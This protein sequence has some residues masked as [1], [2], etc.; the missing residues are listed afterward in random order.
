MLEINLNKVLE[1]F[2]GNDF[3]SLSL[4]VQ[5]ST[6]E[7]SKNPFGGE[8]SEDD[9]F[10]LYE[11]KDFIWQGDFD[12]DD[13][14]TTAIELYELFPCYMLSCEF[15]NYYRDF[16]RGMSKTVLSKL[17]LEFSRFMNM[18][19]AYK[20]PINYVLWVDFFEDRNTQAS[21]WIGM[22][23]ACAKNNNLHELAAISGP[24][25]WEFK[26][27]LYYKLI[28]NKNFHCYILDGLVA[29]IEDVY[30][31]IDKQEAKEIFLKLPKIE[32]NEH[33]DFLEK[34][35]VL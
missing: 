12:I 24:V 34:E 4:K 19:Q 25:E 9:D 31:D 27:H 16:G 15:Y 14:F 20:H 6:I 22:F 29:S 21:S 17:W 28:D 3:S 23:K 18:S 13:K 5:K 26:K 2:P 30:G 8:L 7:S 35:L 1:N 10:L 33:Y 32:D 11:L